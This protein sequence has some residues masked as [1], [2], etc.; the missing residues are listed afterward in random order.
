MKK[1][2]IIAEDYVLS[3][4][5]GAPDARGKKLIREL[6]AEGV[7]YATIGHEVVALGFTED[8]PEDMDT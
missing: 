3:H 2:Q 5:L 8:E 1:Y 7:D 6:L 4:G